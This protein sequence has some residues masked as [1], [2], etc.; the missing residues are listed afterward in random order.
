MYTFPSDGYVRLYT[1]STKTTVIIVGSD[2]DTSADHTVSICASG[3]EDVNAVFVRKGM[4]C[5]STG[6]QDSW[7][8]FLPLA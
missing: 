8:T 7:T 2:G 1:Y 6:G 5:Y 3:S 4:K